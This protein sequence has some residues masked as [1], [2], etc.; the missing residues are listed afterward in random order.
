[1]PHRAAS[2]TRAPEQRFS[3]LLLSFPK[4][5]RTWLSYLYAYYACYRI[6]GDDADAFIDREFTP[7]A[8]IYRPLE[9]QAL[10][11]LIE[12]RRGVIVPPLFAAH[13][14]EPQPYFQ[15]DLALTRIPAERVAFLVRDPR[16]VVV[17]YFHHTMHRADDCRRRGK[18]AP[19][20]DVNVSEFIRSELHGIRAIVAYMNQAAERGPHVFDVFHTV[21]FE[22]LVDAPERVL[23]QI[24]TEFGAQI[25]PAAV[26]AAVRRASFGNLQKIEI[27]RRSK[28]GGELPLNALRFRRGVP[29]AYLTELTEDD[30]NYLDGIIER[31]LHPVFDRYR[32]VAA[33]VAVVQ[34]P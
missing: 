9:H 8:H 24:L 10:A 2:T 34:A 11:A 22:D 30:V 25:E 17:S 5:G 26:A 31:H 18:T 29:R 4:S 21:Y 20:A 15:L 32:G 7:T 14:Y 1:V 3:N 27:A 12:E 33:R 23:T 13:H 16:D 6:L 19:A 28:K